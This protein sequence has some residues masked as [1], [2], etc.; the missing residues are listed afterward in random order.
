LWLPDEG[1]TEKC[2]GVFSRRLFMQLFIHIPKTAGTSLRQELQRHYGERIALAYGA[3]ELT[4]PV[5][6]TRNTPP[7]QRA[8]LE[9]QGVELLFGHVRYQYWRSAFE[10][11]EVL[12]VLRHPVDRCLSHY[13]HYLSHPEDT[14]L[15]RQ[16]QEDGLS[17]RAFASHP[18]S[19]NLQAKILDI[20]ADSLHCL[21][22][23]GG[24]F[25]EDQLADELGVRQRL[26]QTRRSFQATA[27]D[28]LAIQAANHLDLLV[29]ELV[30]Q[31]WR[32]GYWRWTAT[33][34]R[35][36]RWLFW[37]ERCG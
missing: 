12:A 27:E 10:R 2:T 36:K 34:R 37:S 26:N 11:G 15:G 23:F 35:P 8:A 4:H 14:P 13:Q 5:L 1:I 24:L 7:E 3:N 29:Y 31:A 6:Q 20:D 32:E 17:L 28:I 9:A 30:R 18:L 21:S 19:V 16:V 33:L 25:T 22:E